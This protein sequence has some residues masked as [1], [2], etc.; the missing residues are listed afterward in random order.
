[1]KKIL[2]FLLPILI[3]T[4]IVTIFA[5]PSSAAP[6]EEIGYAVWNSEADYLANPYKPVAKYDTSLLTTANL[7]GRG[8]V[9]CYGDVFVSSQVQLD[10]RQEITINLNGYKMTATSKIIVN[11]AS[12]PSWIDRASLKIINGDL[13]HDGNQFIQ[14]RPNSEIYF[15]NVNITENAPGG[16]FMYDGGFRIIHFKN[17]TFT[18]SEK[19][20]GTTLSVSTA[21]DVKDADKLLPKEEDGTFP[22]YSRNI[23]FENTQFINKSEN[24]FKFVLVKNAGRM[25]EVNV[26]FIDGA[27]F[28]EIDDRF[29]VCENNTGYGH[30]YI[31]KGARFADKSIPF[32][33]TNFDITYLDK[34]EVYGE[35]GNF[36]RFGNET[37]LLTSGEQNLENPELIWGKSGDENYPYQLCQ[38][39]CDVTWNINGTETLVE[40]YAD[41]L[42]I[43][44]PAESSGYYFKDDKVYLG[45]HD[46]WSLNEDG[47]DWVETVTLTEKE[48]TY[49]AKFSDGEVVI[50]EYKSPD[51]TIENIEN[52]ILSNQVTAS[53]FSSFKDGSYV[54]FYSD[55][56]Y[57]S[58]DKIPVNSNL[59]IDLGG[60][61]FYKDMVNSIGSGAFQI[62]EGGG[63]TVL[64]G[65]VSSS[66]TNFAFVSDGGVLNVMKDAVLLYDTAALINLSSGTVNFDG[67]TVNHRTTDTYT[68]AILYTGEVGE[69]IVN[70]KNSEINASGAL[71]AYLPVGGEGLNMSLN[72][73]DCEFVY[74]DVLFTL[75][76]TVADSVPSGS[77]M[78]F[79]MVNSGAKTR[80]VFEVAA[81]SN[82]RESLK[83]TYTI[84]KGCYLDAI[85]HVDSG[86]IVLPESCEVLAV[87]DPIFGYIVAET[88]LTFKFNLELMVGF[89]ANFYIPVR[90]DLAFFESYQGKTDVSSLEEVEIDGSR[91]YLASVNGISV[92]DAL[93]VISV[94]IGF[95]DADGNVYALN[96]EYDLVDYFAELISSDDTLVRKLGAAAL[97][98]VKAAYEYSLS[99]FSAKA[100][101]LFES[102]DYLINV[103]PDKEIVDVDDVD[104]GN[105]GVAFTSAQLYLSSDL[106]M[107]FN[108]RSDFSGTLSILDKEYSVIEGKVGECTYIE[109]PIGAL[110][111]YMDVISITG[112]GADN[113]V[114]AG[115]YS[116]VSYV[117]SMSGTDDL[118]TE[119]LDSLFAYC[120]EAFVTYNGGVLP[121]YIDHTP[122]IDAELR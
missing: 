13:V 97:S 108:L 1:M 70:I 114:I 51:M 81:R 57:I 58:D 19:A 116:L 45:I 5:I 98:Y 92:S 68:P 120:Y 33:A 8:Y 84:A 31:A 117:N 91:Y 34:I 53:T 78:T 7:S 50:V 28:N 17:C 27:G 112:L 72:I 11:G 80:E 12:S 119:L 65:K 93:E 96:V 39:L 104:R 79:N 23:I 66:R 94:K 32:S 9:L 75:Y 87:T 46:G 54:R 110:E 82:G 88:N 69:A 61:T 101:E 3:L 113:T 73:E 62:G 107:R 55:V 90:D 59:T 71:S 2:A 74:A 20:G 86:K 111:L 49:F 30:F 121:P 18:M 41:G 89:T 37:D 38:F 6:A 10:R 36:V 106:Y 56:H 100:L 118:L 22:N 42:K 44:Y 52:G 15:E 26:C 40:G 16:Q 25:D 83:G 77:S 24:D 47:S 95:T 76:P 48:A 4:V 29:L 85:P 14:P 43:R 21:F 64:N 122:P 105:I 35:N 102:E 60:N 99:S 63:L 115:E 103:R 67:A 109:I